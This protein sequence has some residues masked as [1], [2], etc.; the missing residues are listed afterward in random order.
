VIGGS[1]NS[2]AE[3]KDVAEFITEAVDFGGERL[4]DDV[5]VLIRQLADERYPVR[6]EATRKLAKMGPMAG[7][8]FRLFFW[9]DRA[10]WKPTNKLPR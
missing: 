9:E 2:A 3:G 5:N 4:A 6:E 1:V 7:R 10:G 8:V